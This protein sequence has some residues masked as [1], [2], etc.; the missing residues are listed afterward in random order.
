MAVKK[1]QAIVNGVTIP[2]TQVGATNEWKA[3]G[4]APA[5]SSYNQTGHYYG[6]T[7]Q[8]WDDAGNM[9]EVDVTDS[10]LGEALKLIVKE[11]VAPVITITYPTASAVLTNNK[12]VIEWKVTDD[13]SG[14]N[15]DTIGITIDSGSKITG[16]AITK[17]AVT[18]GYEC[19]YT[20]TTALSDGSHTIKVDASDNDGNAATQKT[21]TFKV[22]T[23]P[24]TLNI[25]SPAA[26]LVTN[27]ASCTVSGITNDI[28]SSPCKVTIKLNSGAA[29]EVNVGSD[30]AFSKV[31][32]LTQ[33][34]NTITIVSTDSAGKATTVTR[35]VTLDTGAPVIENPVITPN[36]VGT[37]KTFTI[38]VTIKD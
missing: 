3:S 12:P 9:T 20:P 15:P 31:L 33:G 16:S 37:S 23:V 25:S 21:V 30:G 2:L 27:D 10:E 32:T 36:P 8:A 28:T 34:T 1:A 11:A 26:N 6:V 22:D 14:V 38:S 7:I 35:T 19:S 13:D 5:K 24:P 18:G 29:E 4:T 17:T